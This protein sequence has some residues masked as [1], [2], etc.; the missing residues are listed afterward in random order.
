M[1]V[2]LTDLINVFPGNSSVTTVQHARIEEPVFSLNPTDAPIDWMDSDHVICV[3]CRSVSL[4][5]LYK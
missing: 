1:N 3:H 4:P 2:L 5:R